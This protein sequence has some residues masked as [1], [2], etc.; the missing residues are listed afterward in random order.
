M[1]WSGDF[2]Y[3]NSRDTNKD[4]FLR[5][6]PSIARKVEEGTFKVS[7]RGNNV[8]LLYQCDIKG[9]YFGKWFVCCYLCRREKGGEFMTKDIDALSNNCF[10][11]P[12]SWISY[13]DKSLPEVKVYIDK[14]NEW[15]NSERIKLKID[16]DDY[17]KCVA[18]YKIEWNSFSIKTGDTFY[19]HIGSLNP[20][21]KRKQKCYIITQP[22]SVYRS[23]GLEYKMIDTYYRISNSTFKNIKSVIKL[24][25][26][27]INQI[28]E[29]YKNTA[30]NFPKMAKK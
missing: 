25:E 22:S 23:N 26:K 21:A 3:W 28:V 5:T 8:Y 24:S 29:D 10:D 19:V 30:M 2:T 6:R 14:R 13:L 16:F 18:P 4:I 12:K 15:E 27:D 11:F 9:E 17:L 20:W 1:G 7:Q